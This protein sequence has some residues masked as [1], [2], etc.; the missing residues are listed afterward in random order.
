MSSL[1]VQNAHIT[2]SCKFYIN[3]NRGLFIGTLRWAHTC[4]NLF[5]CMNSI[6]A[7]QRRLR[8]F[9][10][11]TV[12]A[13][14]GLCTSGAPISQKKRQAV[15]SLFSALVYRERRSNCH[16]R[17][18]KPTPVILLRCEPTRNEQSCL[19]QHTHTLRSAHLCLQCKHHELLR[20]DPHLRAPEH[21]GGADGA[22]TR[23]CSIVCATC[24][25]S[26]YL[27]VS[28]HPLGY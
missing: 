18:I 2:V 19:Q 23:A 17:A 6:R 7:S 22:G 28:H 20:H 8:F 24:A 13:T 5:D 26:L 14:S 12:F 25:G 1:I 27:S 10:E 3:H 4:V 16:V 11:A 21:T 15:F 9:D